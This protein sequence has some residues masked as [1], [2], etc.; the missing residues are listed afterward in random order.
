VADFSGNGNILPV[1]QKFIVCAKQNL[2]KGFSIKDI[3]QPDGCPAIGRNQ[4]LAFLC[5]VDSYR[6]NRIF[7]FCKILNFHNSRFPGLSIGL[8]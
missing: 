3:Q 7:C 4:R 6:T 2:S 5:L 1:K 8:F